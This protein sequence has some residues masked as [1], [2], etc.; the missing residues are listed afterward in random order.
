[1]ESCKNYITK[2]KV[3]KDCI[4]N[5]PLSFSQLFPIRK[6]PKKAGATACQT[7]PKNS[8]V[9]FLTAQLNTSENAPEIRSN[10]EALLALVYTAYVSDT[11]SFPLLSR[12]AT[13]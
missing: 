4:K 13:E 8:F 11:T 10:N 1:M 2:R 3:K 5:K 7:P 6:T 9:Y 12:A